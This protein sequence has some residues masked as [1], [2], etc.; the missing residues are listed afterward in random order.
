[1]TQ[2]N[3]PDD[4]VRGVDGVFIWD[5]LGMGQTIM[6]CLGGYFG[7]WELSWGGFGT[8]IFGSSRG[9]DSGTGV[10]GFGPQETC[11]VRPML[12]W[13]IVLSRCRF[14]TS[15]VFVLAGGLP[16]LEGTCVDFEWV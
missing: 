1:V 8:N 2:V 11:C 3:R 10:S 5:D 6:G 9:F 14:G 7:F 13:T 4:C 16:H 12:L 15:R